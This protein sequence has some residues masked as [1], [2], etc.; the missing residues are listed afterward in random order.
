MSF[1]ILKIVRGFLAMTLGLWIAGAGCLLGCEGM[2]TAVASEGNVAAPHEASDLSVVV[3]GE[4]CA[5]AK[6]HD[7]CAKKKA[8]A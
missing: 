4:A 5:S 6:T 1:S 2:M 3:S 8:G 7:C